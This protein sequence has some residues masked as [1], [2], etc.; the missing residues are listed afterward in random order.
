VLI[1]DR[2]SGTLVSALGAAS[3]YVGYGL[4]PVPGQPVGPSV[5]PVV[6]GVGLVA[7]GVMIAL[8]VGRGFEEAAEADL[9]AVG[10]SQEMPPSAAAPGPLLLALLPPALLVFYALAVETLGFVPTAAAMVAAM[11]AAFRG[12]PALVLGLAILAP[13]VVHLIFYKLLRVPL[14]AGLLPMPW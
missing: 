4:P 5:F 14:P 9:A 7:C 11:V 1:P 2:I 10:A 13:P 8:G 12:S 3:A 6:I